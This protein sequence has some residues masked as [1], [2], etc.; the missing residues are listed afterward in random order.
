M[1]PRSRPGLHR[2]SPAPRARVQVTKV[3][4]GISNALFKADPKGDLEAVLVR[5][6]GLNTERF[7]DREKEVAIMRLVSDH[8]FGT[9]VLPWRRGWVL[10]EPV[11]EE[12]GALS[13]IVAW[14]ACEH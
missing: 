3:T 13:S 8:G 14:H 10:P 9:K 11:G 4:G 1:R 7:I 12:P 2:A 6:Y 5:V